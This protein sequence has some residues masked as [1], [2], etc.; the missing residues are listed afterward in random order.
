MFVL[1]V[2]PYLIIVALVVM[3]SCNLSQY[4]DCPGTYDTVN[5]CPKSTNG[6]SVHRIMPKA[7]ALMSSTSVVHPTPHPI[8]LLQ[9]YLGHW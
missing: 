6:S 1:L 7:S 3:S 4:Y 9:P 8:L 2:L 5:A